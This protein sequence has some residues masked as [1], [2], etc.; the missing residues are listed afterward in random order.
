MSSL[1]FALTKI[2][3]RAICIMVANFVSR[4]T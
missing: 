4:P 3:F 1:N 2:R